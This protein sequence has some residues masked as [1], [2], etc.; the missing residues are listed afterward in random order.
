[1]VFADHLGGIGVHRISRELQKQV[2]R[3][4]DSLRRWTAERM[5]E[6]A[7]QKTEAV[8]LARRKKIWDEITFTLE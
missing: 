5:M 2:N 7:L 8:I 1:M 3:M 6:V 4:L